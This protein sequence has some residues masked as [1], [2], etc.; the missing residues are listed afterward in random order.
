[1]AV[2]SEDSRWGR[3]TACGEWMPTSY[4]MLSW[5]GAV[6]EASGRRAGSLPQPA[7]SVVSS[8][9]PVCLRFAVTG[10]TVTAIGGDLNPS[11]RFWGRDAVLAQEFGSY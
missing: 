7:L 5:Q 3:L 2:D 4:W 11:A 10:Q 1:M 6:L 9:L 8:G